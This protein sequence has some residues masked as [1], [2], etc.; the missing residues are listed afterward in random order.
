MHGEDG[1]G[2]GT[3][4]SGKKSLSGSKAVLLLPDPCHLLQLPPTTLGGPQFYREG[5]RPLED[6]QFSEAVL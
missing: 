6:N 5:S 4:I 2:R 1:N 3:S